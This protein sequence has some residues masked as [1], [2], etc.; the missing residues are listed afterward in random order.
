MAK[1]FY[2]LDEAAMKLGMSPEE[3]KQ[4]ADAGEFQT[5]RDRDQLMFKAKDVDAQAGG[6]DNISLAD[7]G[8]NDT[9][10]LL[11]DTDEGS[12]AGINVFGDDDEMDATALGGD[13][14]AG[15]GDTLA[16]ES[17]G[18]GSGLLDLTRETDDTSLGAVELLEDVSPS[19]PSDAKIGDAEAGL[20]SSASGIFEGAGGDTLGD[21]E[22]SDEPISAAPA[23]T[24][25]YAY[26]DYDPTGSG[27]TGGLL[28]VAAIALVVAVIIAMTGMQG[29]IVQATSLMTRDNSVLIPCLALGGLALVFMI[30]GL[31][32]GKA[33][34]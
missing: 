31:F 19:E 27:L 15:E 12:A 10:D 9:I 4:K 23:A 7:S 18:S 32:I 17:V 5:F 22:G 28:F 13:T 8:D 16:F 33:R 1:Q 25:A 11:E 34:R 2:S 29:L 3:L 21:L 30:I 20:P 24:A 6:G 14:V 26:D